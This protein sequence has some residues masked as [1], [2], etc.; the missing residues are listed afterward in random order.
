[1]DFKSKQTQSL[2]EDVLKSDVN[3]EE[4][5]RVLIDSLYE[6]LD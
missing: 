5:I 3:R 6:N 1:M 2:F 4:N